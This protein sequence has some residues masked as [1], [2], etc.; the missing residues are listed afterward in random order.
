[1]TFGSVCQTAA[2]ETAERDAA[3]L[4]SLFGAAALAATGVLTAAAG[5]Q[6]PLRRSGGGVTGMLT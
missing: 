2:A 3:R 1:V 4:V 6:A 5:L